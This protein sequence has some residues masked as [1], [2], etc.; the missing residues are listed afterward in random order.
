MSNSTSQSKRQVTSVRAAENMA[1]W[2]EAMEV[3]HALLMAGLRDRMGPDGDVMEAYRLWNQRRR[4]RKLQ[5]YQRAA[6]RYRKWQL[7]SAETSA[8]GT[9]A[10]GTPAT[11]TPKTPHAT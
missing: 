2:Y 4:A 5:A 9:S 10:T 3:S 1:K 8:T 7:D 6:H 11:G